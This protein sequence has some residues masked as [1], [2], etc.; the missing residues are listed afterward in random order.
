M[1]AATHVHVKR[2]DTVMVALG[3]DRGHTGKVLRVF[4]KKGQVLV[5]GANVVKKS[6]KPTQANPTGGFDSREA[7]MPAG[8]VKLVCPSCQKTTR[9]ASRMVDGKKVRYCKKC[10]AVI[11]DNRG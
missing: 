8:K 6:I 9:G 4:P 1:A 10:D 3:K 2:G 11:E 5:E 7:P